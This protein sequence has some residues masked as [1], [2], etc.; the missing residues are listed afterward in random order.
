M[1]VRIRGKNE[2]GDEAREMSNLIVALVFFVSG[3]VIL[4]VGV[5]FARAL[6]R[7]QQLEQKLAAHGVDAEAEVIS[8]RV[9]KITARAAPLYYVAYRYRANVAGGEP[10][11]F[12]RETAVSKDDYESREIGSHIPIRFAPDAPGASL[13]GPGV[14]ETYTTTILWMNTLICAGIGLALVG[15]GI[16][17]AISQAKNYA[18]P[19]SASDGQLLV[20]VLDH[21]KLQILRLRTDGTRRMTMAHSAV[22]QQYPA[23]S[24]DGRHLAFASG[25]QLSFNQLIYVIDANGQNQK[26]LIDQPGHIYYTLA[27]SPDGTQIV[28]GTYISGHREIWLTSVDGT[29]LKKL[30]GSSAYND[31]QPAWSPDGRHIAFERSN[32]DPSQ[33]ANSAIWVMNADGSQ[34]APLTDAVNDDGDPVWAPNGQQIAFIRGK[35]KA[36]VWIMNSDGSNAKKLD[37]GDRFQWD[38]AWSPNGKS[39]AVIGVLAGAQEVV[40]MNADGSNVHQA[41]PDP[42]Y[43]DLG[44]A[45]SPD[46]QQLVVVAN[47]YS[48]HEGQ[49]LIV[50]LAK[51]THVAIVTDVYCSGVPAWMPD[52]RPAQ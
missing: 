11:D 23:W 50:D 48:P 36:G 10:Q 1:W 18:L 4:V 26:A 41:D 14:N 33:G 28:A 24:P 37:P 42:Q 31:S 17:Y 16:A 40:V 22:D 49:L 47:G 13:P 29:N 32:P 44:F 20:S 6:R 39:L 7:R 8:H 52:L 9:G 21:S 38:L 5:I 51:Q 30:S 19:G 45:W 3:G 35:Q 27:W 46:S 34:A 12:V 43:A 2:A 25:D 15:G